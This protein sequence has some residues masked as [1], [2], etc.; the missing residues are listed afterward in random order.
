M[1]SRYI[2]LLIGMNLLWA[3]SYPIFKY[4]TDSISSG[5]LATLRFGICA[6][7]L[8][9]TWPW[10]GPQNPRWSDLPRLAALGIIVFCAAPR[11]QI[12]GV[13][14]G[15]AGDTSLL[16]ALDPLITAIAA[17]VFLREKVPVRRWWGCALGTIGVVLLSRVWTGEAVPM[18]GLAANLL[19][20][21]SF[22]CEAAYSVLGKPILHRCSPMKILGAGAVFGTIANL[23]LD[24]TF[25][26]GSTWRALTTLTPT[27]WVLVLYLAI[28]CTVVG[29]TL[30]YLVIRETEV[31]VTGLTVL[32]QPLA[33]LLLAVVWL[34]ERVHAG[35]LWGSLAI[36]A[37]L[38]VG[39]R[40]TSPA[41]GDLVT[42]SP[43]ARAPIA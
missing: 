12:E 4:L 14:L 38:V 32:A 9:V 2:L 30:W 5:A 17:A 31:N 43:G 22:F 18:R 20:I 37:G 39:M 15:Q 3:A 10:L 23:V 8:M 19:F 27:G 29:Y 24:L 33:G 11:L 28:V 6:V 34:G 42:T 36:I 16:M 40:R 21:L 26:H 7:L 35:Q 41:A 13:H 1:K 25:D